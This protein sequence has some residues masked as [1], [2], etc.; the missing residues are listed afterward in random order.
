MYDFH[1]SYIRNKYGDDTKLLFTD[2]DS[3]AYEIRTDDVYADIKDDIESKLDTIKIIRCSQS[4]TR[5]LSECLRTKRA[6]NRLK[7][8]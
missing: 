4:R 1:Y 6:G 7:S 8:L 2:T 5:R 3:L